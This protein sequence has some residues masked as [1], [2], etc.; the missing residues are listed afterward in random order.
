[1]LPVPAGML[2]PGTGTIEKRLSVSARLV[3][4]KSPARKRRGQAGSGPQEKCR[5]CLACRVAGTI[6]LKNYNWTCPHG[7]PLLGHIP[8]GL[9]QFAL[10]GI[11][12]NLTLI[13]KL[14]PIAFSMFVVILTQSAV[15]S[16]AYA[17][18]NEED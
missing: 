16:S 6:R 7:V 15:T 1:M 12:W 11:A 17:F 3:Q 8:Q 9:P 18:R 14:L 2:K 4:G 5:E 10:P 13:E